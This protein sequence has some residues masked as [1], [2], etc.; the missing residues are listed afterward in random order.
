LLDEPTAALDPSAAKTVMELAN[1]VIAER[2]LTALMVTHDLKHCIDYGSNILQMQQGQII[3]SI[4][5]NQKEH[6]TLSQLYAFF[7]NEH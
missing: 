7:E 6:L 2:K 4:D 1:K 3:R 5:S